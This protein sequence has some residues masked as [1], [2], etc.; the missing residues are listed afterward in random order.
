V[1]FFINWF[2]LYR[3]RGIFQLSDKDQYQASTDNCNCDM[4]IVTA[5]DQIEN[6]AQN[7]TLSALWY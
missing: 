4:D 3:G 1:E 5:P 7:S 6:N 2:T